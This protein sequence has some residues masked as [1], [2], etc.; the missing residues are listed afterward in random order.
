M[1]PKIFLLG[2]KDLEML[3]I[4]ELL[5][6]NHYRE[7][8]N[9]FDKCLSW[10]AKLSLY[11]DVIEANHNVIIY[12]IELIE[13]IELPHNYRAIDHH[14]EK[15]H[16]ASSLEQ[17]ADLLNIKLNTFQKLIAANDSGYIPAMKKLG[18]TE[19]QILEIRQKDRAAQGVSPADEQLAEKAIKHKTVK[20]GVVIIKSETSKFS[21]I[22]DRMF[23]QQEEL[24]IFSDDELCYYGTKRTPKLIELYSSLL[25]EGSAYYGGNK[26]FF[27]INIHTE[28]K[29]KSIIYY[30]REITNL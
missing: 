12:G 16:F 11:E 5:L 25:K 20:N 29:T 4:K 3:A 9:L 19:K 27:G 14:N 18:A 23:E 2:G 6:T 21:T 26:S 7:G 10:G 24:L 28:Q 22:T 1:N 8:V 30:V 17:I 13:D 15:S